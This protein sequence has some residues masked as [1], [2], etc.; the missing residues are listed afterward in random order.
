L[1]AKP[2][3][4]MKNIDIQGVAGVDHPA[5]QAEG[6]LLMKS[7]SPPLV[8]VHL[9]DAY[10]DSLVKSEDDVIGVRVPGYE[11]VH[12]HMMNA[13]RKGSDGTPSPSSPPPNSVSRPAPDD[14]WVLAPFVRK[15]ITLT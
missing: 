1:N 10:P 15:S 7:E 5:H 14:D 4:Y 13:L 2:R 3:T 11:D 12:E 9:A 8:Y 6:W